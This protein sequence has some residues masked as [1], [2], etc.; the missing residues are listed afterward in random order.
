VTRKAFLK[1]L[2]LLALY[3]GVFLALAGNSID[4][5][6]EARYAMYAENLTRGFFAPTDT[7]FLWNGPGYPLVLA[8]FAFLKV[9]WLYA[10]MLN[11]V[12]FFLAVC[13][14]FSAIRSFAPERPALFLAY[15]FGL[16]PPFF[17]E[18]WL[19]LTE[20]F[21]LMLVALFALLV[22][23]WLRSARLGFMFAAAAVCGSIALTKI[24]FG[25]VAT[26]MLL[27]SLALARRSVTARGC[28]PVYALAL[29]LCVPYLFYTYRLTGKVFYWSAAGGDVLYWLYTPY[30]EECGSWKS[31][32]DVATDPAL[33]QH[34]PFYDE[35]KGLNYVQRGERL[36]KKAFENMVRHPGRMVA[37]VAANVGRLWLNFPFSHK[38]QSPRNLPYLVPG[39]MLLG[40]VVLSLYPLIKRRAMLPACILHACAV[41]VL[42]I[43]GH[44]LV[45]ATAR[46]LCTI[47][48]VV[49]I[50]LAY[51]AT[52]LVQLRPADRA[53]VG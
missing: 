16:Y 43:A 29:L 50:V 40:A 41:A 18:L 24:F 10:K 3:F 12:F 47:L 30:P 31:Q 33:A 21:A 32:A 6:D 27:G 37:N 19:L 46:S 38:S 8:P 51:V 44:S 25:Y 17:A 9:P 5:G 23:K 26:A 4:V 13:F 49:F 52:N 1:L 22:L 11:P 35:L 20:P 15:L 48:P 14:V 28:L 45:T 7:L 34:R 36:K 2:P 53:P 42:Y 39:S